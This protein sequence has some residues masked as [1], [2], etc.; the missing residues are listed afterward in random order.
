MA[1]KIDFFESVAKEIEGKFNRV[2]HLLK[3]ANQKSGEYHEEILRQSLNNF[4]SKRYG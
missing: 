2:S 4:F 3:K 1:V